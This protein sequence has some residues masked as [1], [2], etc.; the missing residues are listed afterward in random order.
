IRGR[1]I[2]GAKLGR[3]LGV[4]TA[5]IALGR[6]HSPLTGVFAVEVLMP[7]EASPL[8]A[9]A[10]V[11]VRPSVNGT[12]PLLEVH[13]LDFSRLIYGARLTVIFRAKLRDEQRFASLDAL[14]AQI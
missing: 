2:H 11:G 6:R 8:P 12:K 9:V 14:K 7:G 4:L 10:N 1:V 3:Q 13:L 5:N